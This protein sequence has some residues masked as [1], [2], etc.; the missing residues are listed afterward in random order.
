M[1]R[2]D[3]IFDITYSRN[4]EQMFSTITGRIDRIITFVIILAGCSVFSSISGAMWF[5]GLIAALSVCQVVFQ[6][7]R[8]SGISEGQYRKY[9]TLISD[10][11]SL[12]DDE[13]HSRLKSLQELDANPWGILKKAAHKRAC[14]SLG[15]MDNSPSF[16]HGEMLFSWLAGDLP[17]SS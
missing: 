2:Q 11:P 4:L 16:T 8:A 6:F 13:L 12:T 15:L 14:I 17:K 5:G 9:M 7:S 10:E 3:D 1:S